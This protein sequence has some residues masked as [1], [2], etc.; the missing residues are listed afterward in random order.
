MN[1]LLIIRWPVGGIQTYCKYVYSLPLFDHC[2]FTVVTTTE[3]DEQYFKDTFGTKLAALVRLEDKAFSAAA[4]LRIGRRIPRLEL[5]HAHG[6]SSGI[7]AVPTKLWL[8]APMILT[9]HDIL[10]DG[11][12]AGPAGIMKRLALGTALGISTRV[13]VVGNDAAQNLRT[14]FPR[15]CSEKKLSVILN[16]IDVERF[17]E[18]RHRDLRGEL[19]VAPGTLLL[20]FFGRFMAQKGFK[21]ILDMLDQQRERLAGP[22]HV[23]C[24]GWGG[25]IREEQADIARRGLQSFFSFLP[26]TNDMP[27]A[28]RGCDVVLMPS[29]WEA[30][31]LLAMEVLAAG[32]PLIAT[33]CIGLKEACAG[34]PALICTPGDSQSLLEA[35]NRFMRER[36]ALKAEAEQY[37]GEAVR[38]F[39]RKRTAQSLKDLYDSMV[40]AN[41]G[42]ECKTG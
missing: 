8:G 41:G 19:G 12:L 22:V 40:R 21:Y 13:N 11:Q 9:S 2:R 6:F 29:L 26:A 38:R 15:A 4:I 42:L 25:F 23:V 35:V 28:L 34:S 36:T 31:P 18:P 32:V 3:A 1:V 37:Q 17:S 7:L 5:I 14:Y 39:D 27:P 30:M 10:Q 16:G 24:F 20:G 33:S